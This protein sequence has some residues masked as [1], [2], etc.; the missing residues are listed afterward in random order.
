[1]ETDLATLPSAREH[2]LRRNRESGLEAVET[3]LAT[4]PNSPEHLLRRNRETGLEA[5]ETDLAEVAVKERLNG[6]ALALDVE[7]RA[8]DAGCQL[9]LTG[10]T[11][12][13]GVGTDEIVVMM[14]IG[15]AF[16]TVAGRRRGMR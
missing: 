3:D 5:V 10:A 7:A 16:A 12:L 14:Q 4:L 8:Y 9:R 13:L 1:M 15:A 2:L 6:T 11:P